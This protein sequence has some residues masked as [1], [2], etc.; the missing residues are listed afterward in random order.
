VLLSIVFLQNSKVS[1]RL[2]PEM[3]CCSDEQNHETF[4]EI[5]GALLQMIKLECSTVIA[6]SILI[7]YTTFYFVYKNYQEHFKQG[8]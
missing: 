4:N 8:T 1:P 3:N 2:E 5:F 7:T 6:A